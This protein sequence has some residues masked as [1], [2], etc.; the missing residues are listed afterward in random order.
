MW[1]SWEVQLAF[2]EYRQGMWSAK[3]ISDQRLTWDPAPEGDDAR[4]LKESHPR[5]PQ[6]KSDLTFKTHIAN[7]VLYVLCARREDG[8]YS[9]QGGF[10]FTSDAQVDTLSEGGLDVVRKG[11]PVSSP[12]QHGDY[13]NMAVKAG[14][15]LSFT[16][17]G[18]A[19][20]LAE[21]PSPFTLI[22]PHQLP[23]ET[24]Q[25]CFFYQD[26]G[27]GPFRGT[28]SE[29]WVHATMPVRALQQGRRPRRATSL[30]RLPSRLR[31][32][33]SKHARMRAALRLLVRVRVGR[34]TN[35]ALR[36]PTTRW[37]TSL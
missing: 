24:W 31:V 1:D 33:R 19:Q 17:N 22:F 11:Y 14:G 23:Q 35:I 9:Y 10:R 18:G 15:E 6:N 16:T 5:E 27:A 7:E 34:T 30:S 26:D 13:E 4:M 37:Y 3:K 21:S 32:S 28:Q 25:D 2:S 36:T 29:R 8:T 12:A 20:I